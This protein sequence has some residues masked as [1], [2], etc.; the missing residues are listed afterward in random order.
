MALGFAVLFSGALVAETLTNFVE[1]GS[2]MDRLQIALEEGL[3]MVGGTILLWAGAVFLV[4]HPSLPG[5]AKLVVNT[6]LAPQGRDH[7]EDLISTR[8]YS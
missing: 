1:P 6:P 8:P 3:E 4:F 5:L 2:V 7:S